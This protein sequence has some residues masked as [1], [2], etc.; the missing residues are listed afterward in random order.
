MNQ[1]PVNLDD[2]ARQLYAQFGGVELRELDRLEFGKNDRMLQN[3]AEEE[4][5]AN[6][7]RFLLAH[8]VS[9]ISS[10][11]QA[12]PRDGLQ[13]SLAPTFH[14]L[15]KIFGKFWQKPTTS[16]AT[17]IRYRGTA[18]ESGGS[19]KIDY[20][21][22]C[23]NIMLDSQV[24]AGIARKQGRENSRLLEQ[25]TSAFETF[26]Q[27]GIN[28]FLLKI[29]ISSGFGL[30]CRLWPGFSKRWRKNPTSI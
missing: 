17:L 27:H 2:E 26:S 14:Q 13:Q 8:M 20:E 29:P 16:N 30:R 1:R 11:L 25:L 12:L 21:I 23:G 4:Q 22:L 9:G 7:I 18:G 28:N 5:Q 6:A 3:L 10:A 19:D 24:A 15:E